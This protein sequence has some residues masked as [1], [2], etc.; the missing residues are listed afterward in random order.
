EGPQ[1]LLVQFPRPAEELYDLENDP[2]EVSNLASSAS[3]AHE[4][5][6]LRQV[7]AEWRAEVGDWGETPE[8]QMVAQWWPGGEQPET[9]A[10]VIVPINTESPGCEVATDNETF[11]A[12][13]LMQIHCATQGASIGYTTDEGENPQWHLYC[14]PLRLPLGS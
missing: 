4:M 12:S 6:R 2:W 7:L 13:L 9:A 11:K 1:T 10:P 5:Q 8:A 14:Q 3:H